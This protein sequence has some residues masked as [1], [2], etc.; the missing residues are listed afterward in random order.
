MTGAKVVEIERRPSS[1][2]ADA[3]AS[4]EHLTDLGNARRLARLHGLDLRYSHHRQK[5]LAWNGQRWVLDVD[6]EAMRRA[7]QV[8]AEMYRQ[9]AEMVDSGARK[10]LVDHARKSEAEQRLKAMIALAASEPGIPVAPDDLDRN[11]M[12]FN[13]ENGTIELETGALREHRRNDLITKLSPVRFDPDATCDQ[14]DQFLVDILP[15]PR[16][17]E[18]VQRAI[19]YAFTGQTVEQALFIFWGLGANGK[20]TFIET[21]MTLFGD[22]ALKTPADTLLARRDTGIPNDVARLK[23]ARLVSAVEMEEGKK[24]AEIRVKELTGG[25]TISARFMRGEWFDFRPMCKIVIAT[26]HRP[27]V[28]G[29]DYAIWRRIRLIPFTVTIS[30]NER[31]PRLAEK[32]QDELPGILNWAIQGCLAWQRDGLKPPSAVV[33]ATKEYRESEDQVGEFL[34]DRCVVGEGH[35][36]TKAA[37]HRAY[38]DWC[39]GEGVLGPRQ[40]TARLRERGVEDKRTSS[41]W[42]WVGVGLLSQLE[43]DR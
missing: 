9:A 41:A 32:L 36:V 11:L 42:G 18:F 43:G 15:D 2:Q 35:R 13:V 14:W 1:P 17:R 8:V 4:A 25:D 39:G 16:V 34:R 29:T 28:R 22:Y 12:I 26:N 20:S 27:T 33:S 30:E 37:L 40:F 10:L 23:G 38:A 7:T 3:S 21:M 31:D 19:G 24:L 6:G 5:W